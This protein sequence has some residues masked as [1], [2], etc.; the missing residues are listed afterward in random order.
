MKHFLKVLSIVLWL[1]CVLFHLI[2]ICFCIEGIITDYSYSDA[3]ESDS[4]LHKSSPSLSL[5]ES[6]FIKIEVIEEVTTEEVTE[7][8]EEVVV[9]VYEYTEEE[10]DLLAR[11]IHSEGGIES[12]ETQLMIGSVVMNRVSEDIYFPD[13]IREVIYQENQFSVTFLEENGILM[14]DK[15]A[16]DEA[17]RAAYEVLTYGSI[18]PADVQVFFHK[19]ITSGW[20]STREPYGTFDNTTFAYIYRKGGS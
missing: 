5:D 4:V 18:L 14:I 13:T 11:L 2:L 1:S 12:Y 20:V 17:K 8:L 6:Q 16:D 3:V 19:R 9:P 10:F 15:P 7:A